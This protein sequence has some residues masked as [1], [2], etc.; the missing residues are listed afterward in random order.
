VQLL[1]AL[2]LLVGLWTSSVIIFSTA[3]MFYY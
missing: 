2:F 3:Y 1:A